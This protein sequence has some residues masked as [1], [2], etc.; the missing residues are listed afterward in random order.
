MA[1][2][3]KEDAINNSEMNE[4]ARYSRA[5]ESHVP[6]R[7]LK[8]TNSVAMCYARASFHPTSIVTSTDVEKEQ[9]VE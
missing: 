4:T 6:A 9:E 2:Q 8:K 7:F 5:V 1:I 3:T